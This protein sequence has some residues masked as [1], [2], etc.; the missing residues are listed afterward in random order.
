MRNDGFTN[1]L[2]SII[3]A[4]HFTIPEVLIVMGSKGYRA[5]CC[6][7]LESDSFESI[8]SPNFP[9]LVEFKVNIEIKWHLVLKR[10]E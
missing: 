1:I 3:L 4:G 7:Q 9:A 6:R 2:D 8:D 5:N 10:K